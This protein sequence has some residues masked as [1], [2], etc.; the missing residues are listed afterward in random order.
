MTITLTSKAFWDLFEEETEHQ[1]ISQPDTFDTIYSYPAVLGKGNWREIE[2]REGMS[3]VISNY[4]LHTGCIL[5]LPERPHPLEFILLLETTQR[6]NHS[7]IKS[8][9]YELFG[10]GFAP[11]ETTEILAAKST[12]A[13]NV[14]IDLD[15]FQSFW[16][17]G[18][19]LSSSPLKALL[20]DADQQYYTHFGMIT[21]AMQ[22]AAQHILQCPYRGLTKRMY[23]ES[24][25]WELMALLVEEAAQDQPRPASRPRLKPEDVERIY[26]ARDILLQQLGDPPSLLEL[27]RQVGLNDCTLKRGFR[28]VFGT[29]AFGLL[30]DYRLEQARQ[31]LESRDCNI[32]EVARSVGFANRSYFANAFRKK[33]GINPK[34]Y[35]SYKNSA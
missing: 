2:L 10:S 31:L 35:R 6:S 1:P 29:T 8:G 32:S 30:H 14:H 12:L 3:L 17:H 9:R 34:D 25:V 5:Q 24:K 33:F 20:R 21:A 27:A 23:L 28:Q 22:I 11:K 26:Q 16:G 18:S 7:G 13:I 19:E 15:V 4:C